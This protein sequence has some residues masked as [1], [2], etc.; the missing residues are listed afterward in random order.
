M[1][2]EEIDVD[3]DDETTEVIDEVL[4]VQ[5]TTR[6]PRRGVGIQITKH[7][8]T[9]PTDTRGES[10]WTRTP[11]GQMTATAKRELSRM[12]NSKEG[13]RLHRTLKENENEQ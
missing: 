11:Q 2:R 4:A 3:T 13:K 8:Q 10:W 7:R 5:S 1:S 9:E 12:A 6:P